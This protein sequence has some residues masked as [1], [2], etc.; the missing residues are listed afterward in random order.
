MQTAEE[1]QSARQAAVELSEYFAESVP[2]YGHAPAVATHW[3][4]P[5]HHATRVT[6]DD[7][8]P[9]FVC[10]ACLADW[11]CPKAGV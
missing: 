4:L 9:V 1:R 2:G 11:P 5:R 6:P 3:V 10:A 8:A 7:A